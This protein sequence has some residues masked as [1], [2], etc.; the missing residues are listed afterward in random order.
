MHIYE[1]KFR[2][3]LRE[4]GL[5]FTPERRTI[6]EGVFSLHGHFDADQLYER[7]KKQNRRL[8]HAS[9]YR[10]FPLL[11]KRNLISEA[12]SCQGRA[13][14]EHILGHRHHDHM[15]CV[16]CGRIIE[17]ENGE[18]ERLQNEA[19]RKY[20]FVPVAHKLGIR[21]YCRKCLKKIKCSRRTL[22]P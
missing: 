18:I 20:G 1:K 7:L 4:K 3:S 21:G 9:I 8:S 2:E 12:L 11:V 14:Y 13:S 17:F 6:L 10:T 16:E 5:K 19:C 15:V 22:C